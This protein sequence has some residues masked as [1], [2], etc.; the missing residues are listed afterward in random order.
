MS[1]IYAM[2]GTRDWSNSGSF[3][4]AIDGSG[5]AGLPSTGDTLIVPYET[6]VNAGLTGLASVDLAALYVSGGG[7]LTASGALTLQVSDSGAGI[8]IINNRTGSLPILSGT[9]GIDELVWAP[10]S[11]GAQV[12]LESGGTI[13]VFKW[14]GGQAEVK[15]SQVVTTI[16]K[17]GGTGTIYDNGT[18]VTTLYHTGG[19]LDNRR[20]ITTA[21]N[22]GSAYLQNSGD[23][24][25][26]TVNNSGRINDRSSAAVT[27]LNMYGGLYDPAGSPVARA[28]T[29]V[30]RFNGSVITIVAGRT[31]ITAG[32]YNNFTAEPTAQSV[33]TIPPFGDA[34][35]LF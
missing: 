22:H 1:T 2:G 6:Y 16:Y 12:S 19:Y 28:I 26:A 33:N 25:M 17:L 18:A 15:A 35:G 20:N 10:V 7:N 23:A 13:P 5:S 24:A 4:T 31:L 3:N 27:T 21:H 9:A 32:T 29:T 30:N 8:A 11:G 14:Y 34:S